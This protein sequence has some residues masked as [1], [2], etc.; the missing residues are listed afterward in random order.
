MNEVQKTVLQGSKLEKYHQN[1]ISQNEIIGNLL[2]LADVVN[3]PRPTVRFEVVMTLY[4]AHCM[5][6]YAFSIVQR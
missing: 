4:T 6:H 2:N 1:R 3:K 5:I